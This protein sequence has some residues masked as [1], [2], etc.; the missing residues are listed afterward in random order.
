M[1]KIKSWKIQK[2]KM[3]M[4][5]VGLLS[6][7]LA[8]LACSSAPDLENSE[9]TKV[10]ESEEAIQQANRTVLPDLFASPL[11]RNSAL[12]GEYS[13]EPPEDLLEMG[14]SL[15]QASPT[16]LALRARVVADSTRCQWRGVARTAE[17]REEAIRFWLN[18][19]DDDELPSAEDAETQLVS[20][21]EKTGPI[22]EE[23]LKANVRSL[24]RGGLTNDYQFLTCYTEYNPAEY[25]VGSTQG[26]NQTVTVAYD[27]LGEER[28]Y[29]LYQASHTA[30]EFGDQ[31]LMSETDYAA[32]LEDYAQ[33]TAR[34]LNLILGNN[35]TLLFLAP[36]GAHNA[37]AVEAWQA[38]AQWDLQE[39]DSG[40]TQAIR[41]GANQTD[42]EHSQT[43][44]VLKNRITTAAATDEFA[45]SRIANV[46]GLTQYYRDIGAYDDITPHDGSDETFMPA[47]PPAIPVCAD[48]TAVGDSPD[49]GLVDDC[50]DL[51]TARDTLAG[52]ASLN[53]SNDTAMSEWDGVRLGG[54]PQR[55]Q[56][57]LLTDQDLNGSIPA[58]L[59]NLTQLRRIDLDEND[60][61][62]EIPPQL[63]NLKKLTHLYLFENHLNGAIPPELGY[64]NSLQVLYLEDNQLTG[65]IPAKLGKLSNIRQLVL[66]ENQL[67]GSVPEEIGNIP[68]LA[69]LILKDNNLTGQIPR[70]LSQLTFA[71]LA[72]SGN[73][74]TGCLPT[75]LD[76]AGSNDLF[77]PELAALPSCAP[78]F[79]QDSYAFTVNRNAT[80]GTAVGTPAATP[81]EAG[82][83]LAY[84]ITEGNDAGLFAINAATGTITTATALPGT[85]GTTYTMT[86]TATDPHSQTANVEVSV[87]LT[88]P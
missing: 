3:Y 64:M 15:A 14:L 8:I 48:S 35:E 73:S 79:G 51:L 5:S 38:I 42:S 4:V 45:D 59:G 27:R 77:R 82:D 19:D 80:T 47:T 28:S 81:Y 29:T 62:G 76:Q 60:L 65:E 36:M 72:L 69:H 43:L 11:G 6:I 24:A 88:T 16:H 70:P 2:V 83:T 87:T 84:E 68:G 57:L 10:V 21:I 33:G 74:F 7:L 37:I 66:G 40:T 86:V 25:L 9:Q 58:I 56:Y 17:Q 75:G 1:D 34:I 41:Y 32:H 23:T 13:S 49:P 53:W 52:T 78:N 67:S 50:N 61:T 22:Y 85:D 20:A 63:G 55:V 44:E 18:L 46:S 54:S 12:S 39:D 26:S 30:G 71:N 31:A